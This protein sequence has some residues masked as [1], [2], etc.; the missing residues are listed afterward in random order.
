MNNLIESNINEL[1]EN[2]LGNLAVGGGISCGGDGEA[3]IVNNIICHNEVSLTLTGVHMCNLLGGGIYCENS[4]A[5]I[6]NNLIYGNKAY[7]LYGTNYAAGGGIDCHPNKR[8]EI[9]NTIL[10]A[11]TATTEGDQIYGAHVVRYCCVQDGWPGEGNIDLDPM[12]FDA[13]NGDFHL[14]YFSPCVDA[15]N[16]ADVPAWLLKDY[17]GQP[18]ILNRDGYLKYLNGAAYKGIV[19]IG[20]DEF[21][22]RRGYQPPTDPPPNQSQSYQHGPTK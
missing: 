4:N 3:Y 20:A 21:L 13:E 2:S 5:K 18:R 1:L 19:D 22:L 9:I 11:N 15:G 6:I 8:P 12:F 14:T 7:Y 10:W 17:E 16:N